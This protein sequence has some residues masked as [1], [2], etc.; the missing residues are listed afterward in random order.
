MGKPLVGKRKRGHVV[1]RQKAQ[2][3]QLVELEK[4]CLLI[5]G[6]KTSQTSLSFLRDIRKL[7]GSSAK[8]FSRKNEIRPLED[9]TKLEFLC[10]KNDAGLFLF[11]SHNKKRPHN[12][13]MGRLYNGH[14]LDMF[15]MGIKSYKS[16]ED[17]IKE[18]KRAKTTDSPSFILFQGDVFEKDLTMKT[19]KSM[20]LDFF[21]ARVLE[22]IDIPSVDHLIVISA[23]EDTIYVR[24]YVVGFKMKSS[25]NKISDAFTT[26]APKCGLIEMGPSV[27]LTLRRSRLAAPQLAKQAHK[28]PKQNKGPKKIKNVSR[29]VLHGTSG[30]IHMQKQDVSKVVTR[31]RFRKALKKK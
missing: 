4:T 12:L 14:I 2:E 30:R 24:S 18:N 23:D 17:C 21:K 8:L 10:Q 15:E 13:V 16:I 3:P 6:A 1:R 9:E 11:A 25:A 31:S 26:K 20:F 7:K 27:D 29:D 19:L 28:Q 22:E 5:R